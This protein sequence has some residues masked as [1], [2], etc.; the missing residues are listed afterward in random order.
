MNNDQ[1]LQSSEE[2]N[3]ASSFDKQHTQAKTVRSADD[4]Q[5]RLRT[6]LEHAKQQAEEYL[7][8]WKRA[9]ADYQNLKRDTE[10]ETV[11]LAKFANLS[12]LLELLPIVDNFGRAIR[13]L[14][15]ER[16]NDDAV[17]N[18]SPLG[19]PHSGRCGAAALS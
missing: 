16:K 5:T 2:H 19:R 8:G 1:T 9:Q 3:G 4:E 11:K 10:K 18:A 15:E 17:G 6:E 13:H 12:L 14:P 7:S